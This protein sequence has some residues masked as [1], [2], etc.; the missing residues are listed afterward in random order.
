MLPLSDDIESRTPPFAVILLILANILAYVYVTLQPD[1]ERMRLVL[2]YGAMPLRFTNVEWAQWAGFPDTALPF[3]TYMFLHGDLLHLAFNLWTM[4]VFADN[5]EDA[6]GHFRFPIFFLICGAAALAAH[7]LLNPHSASPVVGASGAV[8]GVMGAYILLFPKAKILTLIPIFF[9]PA[10]IRL[11]AL[12]L[13]GVWFLLQL[14]SGL[15]A[16]TGDDGGIAWWAHLGGF[17]AGLVL[18]KPFLWGRPPLPLY[19]EPVPHET[20]PEQSPPPGTVD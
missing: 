12:L 14:A 17:G 16:L 20:D 19:H 18:T 2:T 3:L 7:I 15:S 6:M 8:A 13:L 4:W 1:A 5:V 10:L 9:F 11:P